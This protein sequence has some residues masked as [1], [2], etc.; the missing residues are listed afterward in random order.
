MYVNLSEVF[1]QRVFR[2][3]NLH[4]AVVRRYAEN[5]PEYPL[6][7]TNQFLRI[8]IIVLKR[9]LTSDLTRDLAKIDVFD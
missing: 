9:T 6:S 2:Y 1:E 3:N 7:F 8:R 5:I 4:F